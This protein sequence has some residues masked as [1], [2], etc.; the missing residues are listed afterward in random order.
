MLVMI[1]VCIKPFHNKGVSGNVPAAA[2]FGTPDRRRHSHQPGRGRA[3]GCGPVATGV[4]EYDAH[5]LG[6]S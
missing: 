6:G 4:W 3:G 2:P 1:S 5:A